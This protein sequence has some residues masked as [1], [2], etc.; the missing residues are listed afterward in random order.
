M[1][2]KEKVF[3]LWGVMDA[4]EA[5]YYSFGSWAFLGE[6]WV[7]ATVNLGMIFYLAM[8]SGV[9]DMLKGTYYL[10]YTLMPLTLIL[11]SWF[12]SR[13]NTMPSNSPWY[14]RFFA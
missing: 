10:V 4:V 14:R 7:L 3:Y 13:K 9:D 12:F 2:A 1:T 5:V 11:S 6:N 8:F